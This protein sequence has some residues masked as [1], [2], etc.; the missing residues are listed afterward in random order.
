MTFDSQG[1]LELIDDVNISESNSRKGKKVS[2][3]VNHLEKSGRYKSSE[4]REWKAEGVDLKKTEE[5]KLREIKD[6]GDSEYWSLHKAGRKLEPLMF[7]NG[8]SQEDVVKEVVGLIESGRKVV[9]LHGVCGTG[10]SA[11]ALN[12]ARKLGR[13][14]IVVPVK[15]LQRQYEEDYMKEMF[16]LKG[17]GKEMKISMITGR[18]NHDSIFKSGESCA[19][20]SLPDNIQL[21]EKNFQQLKE[22]YELNPLI[23]NKEFE[24]VKMLRRISVAPANPYWSPI[25]SADYDIKLGDATRKRYLGLRGK[26]FIFYHR[27]RGCSY[28]DQYQSYINSDVV[29]FN[30]AKYKIEV[31]LDRKPEMDVDIIDEADEFLDSFS[32]EMELNLTRLNK[33]IKQVVSTEAGVAAILDTVTELVSLEEKNKAALGIDE[34]EVFALQDTNLG[35]VLK[36]LL[37]DRNVESELSLDDSNY[38][39]KAVEVAKNFSEFFGDTYL[40]YR[41]HEDNL[42]ASLVTTNLSSRLKEVLDKNKA[43]VFMSGT[44]HSERVLKEV[45]GIEDYAVVEAEVVNRGEI[46]IVRT[47]RE[48]DCSY[49]TFKSGERTKEDYFIALQSCVSDATKPMLVHVNAFED[50][51]SEVDSEKFGKLMSKDQLREL[52]FRDKTGRLVSM[53]KHGLSD[54]LYST[55]CSRGVDFPGGVCRS[56]VFTKYP[57]PNVRGVFWKILQKTHPNYFW[58][59]YRD[60]AK[61]EFLQ[62]LYR[63]LR[64]KG[65]HVYVLSPDLRVLNAVRDLQLQNGI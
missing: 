10:K 33:S 62:R 39:N 27:K 23:G 51:P 37:K 45:F 47:G 52:Q 24:D 5:K 57:N 7:S 58:E 44:L 17:D 9:F 60:K 4:K 26:E 18:D 29:I 1:K 38:G 40:T 34:E 31:A 55:K 2:G 49:R 41:R 53:F 6:A 46:E 36:L 25:I 30:S 12:I 13:A 28:Y 65:D 42:Y 63:A 64:S 21:V 3:R 14:A 22:Y 11:I 50:L 59:F 19:D 56:V 35:K 54:E 15:S 16:V 61:R 8:K 43:F 48:F 20:P 32:N